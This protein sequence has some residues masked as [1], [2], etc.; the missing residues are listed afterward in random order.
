MQLEKL[1][2]AGRKPAGIGNM[3]AECI[4]QGEPEQNSA[5]E[6]I[7]VTEQN[8][9]TEQN[10]ATEKICAAG[11][12][13]T[14]EQEYLAQISTFLRGQDFLRLG[15]NIS[16][17]QWNN[18][19]MGLRRMRE[20]CKRLGIT[21]FDRWFSGISESARNRNREAGLQI[22][23]QVTAKR[24]QLLKCLSAEETRESSGDK[25]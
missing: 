22:M 11:Q 13:R 7:S 8:S 21:C 1:G 3:T 5:T 10:T 16:M 4:R 25:A 18:V 14:E 23:A 19:L 6:Q 20:T 12:N 24:V 17:E 2:A 9:A 15:H